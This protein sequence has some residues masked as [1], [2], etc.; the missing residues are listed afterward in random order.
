MG[1]SLTKKAPHKSWGNRV[2]REKEKRKKE[3]DESDVVSSEREE[4]EKA[5]S[6]YQSDAAGLLQPNQTRDSFLSDAEFKDLRRPG[7][8]KRSFVCVR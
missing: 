2:E 3:E 4:E 6:L 1:C 5:L 7:P 8:R